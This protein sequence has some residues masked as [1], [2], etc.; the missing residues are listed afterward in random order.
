MQYMLQQTL[1]ESESHQ[2]N[3]VVQNVESF[4]VL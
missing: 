2:R 1:S 4:V 3:I